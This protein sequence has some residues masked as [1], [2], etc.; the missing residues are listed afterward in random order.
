MRRRLCSCSSCWLSPRPP[1]LRSPASSR[2]RFRR[3]RWGRG[4]TRSRGRLVRPDPR[5]ACV[6]QHPF[7]APDPGSNI[8]NDAYQSDT[9]DRSGRSATTSRPLRPVRT[10]VR[11]GHL[12]SPGSDRDRARGARPPGADRARPPDPPPVLGAAAA[13]APDR[14]GQSLHEL[15][16]RRLLLPR[17][18]RPRRGAHGR[19]TDRDRPGQPCRRARAAAPARPD[20]RRRPGRRDHRGDARL[21]AGGSG[22]PRRTGWWAS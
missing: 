4:S 6:P 12:R 13:T 7:M 5:A 21:G 9:Y 19:A 16:R 3:A 15:R 11:V 22:S 17:P 18:S 20:R 14:H 2:R 1:A 10:R 8:H